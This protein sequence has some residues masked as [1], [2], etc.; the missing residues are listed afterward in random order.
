MAFIPIFPIFFSFWIGFGQGKLEPE[1]PPKTNLGPSLLSGDL[2]SSDFPK[3]N[4]WIFPT[5]LGDLQDPAHME[6]RRYYVPYIWPGHGM[7]VWGWNLALKHRALYMVGTSNTS[8]PVAWPLICQATSV[9]VLGE[10]RASSPRRDLPTVRKK[11]AKS[12]SLKIC[13]SIL[14]SIFMK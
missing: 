1:S 11:T 10:S 2:R 12:E 3:T 8:G 14:W 6:L 7:E 9:L 5:T 4:P 13:S